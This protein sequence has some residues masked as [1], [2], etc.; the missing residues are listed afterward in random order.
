MVLDLV[1]EFDP[2]LREEIP[3]FDFK[4]PPCDP[5]ELA[6]NLIETLHHHKGLGLSSNQCGLKY[7]AF[8]L[9]SADPLVCFNPRILDVTT[10][11]IML[12]ESCVTYPNMVLKVKRPTI[13]KVRFQNCYGEMFNEKFIGMTSRV[14]QHEL[15]HLNGI[16][17]LTKANPVH[18][19][20]A[21]NQQKQLQRAA[22]RG[23]ITINEF[24][25]ENYEQTIQVQRNL[26][27]LS[28]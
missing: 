8:A 20:R 11:Q 19:Q 18:V 12:E 2:I 13:I 22:K 27:Q 4:D 16:N 10:E 7:R 5:V 25:G 14:F 23:E 3:A 21:R 1:D 26:L 6:N 9:W 17:F 28:R 15:D 24:K